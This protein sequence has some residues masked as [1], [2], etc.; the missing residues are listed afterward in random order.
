MSSQKHSIPRSRETGWLSPRW[1]A[2]FLLLVMA[3]TLGWA[4]YTNQHPE[5]G[6]H[7]GQLIGD[8]YANFST[9]LFSIAITVLI[10]DVLTERRLTR[11]EKTELILRMGSRSRDVAD[12]AVSRLRAK[13][14]L[15]SGV[16]QGAY[17][18]RASLSDVDLSRADL[19]EAFL[20][21]A[22]LSWAQLINANLQGA[23]LNLVNLSDA[24][25]GGAD[26][27]GADLTRADL[28]AAYLASA[29]LE[30]ATLSGATHDDGTRWPDGFTPPD[31]A[32]Y[33]P[34]EP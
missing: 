6:R 13:G 28:R 18:S 34:G 4:G 24:D 25:L 15:S 14:W 5:E 31:T 23:H 19:S 20:V 9:E 1:I 12:E 30:G 22:D 2:A 27:A 33:K 26:L 3:V 21:G 29:N 8:F 16:L 11:Q 10:I 17:L 7:I 32:V